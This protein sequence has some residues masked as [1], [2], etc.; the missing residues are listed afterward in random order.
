[1][2]RL[3]LLLLLMLVIFTGLKAQDNIQQA[4][5]AYSK[6]EFDRAAEYFQQ[7]LQEQGESADIYYNIGNCYYKLNQI[8]PAILNYERALLLDPGNGDIRFNLEIARLKTVNKIDS[9][10]NFFLQNW[11]N[12][13]RDLLGTNTWSKIAI[14]C[15]ISLIACLI[16]FFF[17][18][19]ILFKKV[20]FYAGIVLVVFTITANLFA[21][22]QKK[23]LEQRDTAIVFAPTVTIKSSPDNSGTDLFVLH[24]GTKVQIKSQ[25]GDWFEIII[26]D[27]NIGWIP[28]KDIEII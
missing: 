19:K 9:V 25:L 17:S 13:F 15:F 2:K 1:M 5:D 28:K 3:Y 16:L 18:R 10:G 21:F 20:G 22:Q 26:A 14:F 6:G 11:I 23:E 7:V 4:S 24:E 27:G 12:S 8:A